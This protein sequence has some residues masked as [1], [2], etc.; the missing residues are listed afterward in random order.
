MIQDSCGRFNFIADMNKDGVF[1]INDI[2]KIAE[3]IWFLPTKTALVLASYSPDLVKLL[4]IHCKTGVS[5]G[6]GVFSL[7]VWASLLI[8]IVELGEET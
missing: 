7:I 2:G 4:A 5:W 8:V 1:D 6:G 3:F